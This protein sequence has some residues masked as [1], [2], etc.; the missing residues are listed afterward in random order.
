MFFEGVEFFG[1]AFES[2]FFRDWIF[3]QPDAE[4]E[5]SQ[6]GIG[7]EEEEYTEN[8]EVF[9][10]IW[11]RWEIE[12]EP[13]EELAQED[14]DK[15]ARDIDGEDALLQDGLVAV[16]DGRNNDDWGKK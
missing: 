8:R 6:Y 5:K 1:V 16:E 2:V 15:E 11:H 14:G 13:E 3:E 7:T 9:D 12:D 10:D 4:W